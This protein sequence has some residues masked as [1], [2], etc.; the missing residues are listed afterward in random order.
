MEDQKERTRR[1]STLG[2]AMIH[3]SSGFGSSMKMREMRRQKRSNSVYFEILRSGVVCDY[4][5][6]GGGRS[7]DA[8]S[9]TELEVPFLDEF[10]PRSPISM[11]SVAQ[12]NNENSNLNANNVRP[13][14]EHHALPS[15][16]FS[17]K[18][19]RIARRSELGGVIDRISSIAFPIAF[20]LFNAIYWTYYL[21]SYSAGT[22]FKG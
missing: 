11:R 19:K 12:Q 10:R 3:N 8:G 14:V 4:D 5:T 6:R 2:T 15:S 1:L 9:F 21:S 20:G 22:K 13:L 17:K 7:S 18:W 16:S